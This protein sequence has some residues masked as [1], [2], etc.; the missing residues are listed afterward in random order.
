MTGRGTRQTALRDN[1]FLSPHISPSFTPRAVDR[2]IPGTCTSGA[3][4]FHINLCTTLDVAPDEKSRSRSQYRHSK[5]SARIRHLIYACRH[6]RPRNS[7][8]SKRTPKYLSNV[9][10]QTIRWACCS[11]IGVDG[12]GRF[13]VGNVVRHTVGR[14]TKYGV[15]GFFEICRM[16]SN[17]SSPWSTGVCLSTTRKRRHFDTAFWIVLARLPQG[18]FTPC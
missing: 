7:Q 17:K 1:E 2:E 8:T 10:E 5:N 16:S 15:R 3:E 9:L 6:P 13:I 18:S 11:V 4:Q 14:K 12:D